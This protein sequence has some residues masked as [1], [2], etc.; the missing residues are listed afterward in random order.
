[1]TESIVTT[2]EVL[3]PLPEPVFLRF[4]HLAEATRRSLTELLLHAVEV[5]GPPAWDDAPAA[6]QADLAG[7][8]RLDDGALWRIARDRR[9][10]LEMDRFQVLLE[11]R[12]NGVMTP[13]EDAELDALV[14]E[15]DRFTLRKAHAAALLRWRGHVVPPAGQL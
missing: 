11:R 5:G 1:M 4:Q 12:A 9:T 3:L 7:L 10:E 6:F 14:V 2:Q 8:D 15:A 13:T